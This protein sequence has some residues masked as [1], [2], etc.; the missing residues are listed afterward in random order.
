MVS[1]FVISFTPSAYQYYLNFDATH[2]TTVQA[3]FENRVTNKENVRC[4]SQIDSMYAVQ[5]LL[6]Q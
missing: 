3:T 4:Y 2:T 1:C 6:T 5:S